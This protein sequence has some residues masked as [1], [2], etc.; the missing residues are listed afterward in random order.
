MT[1]DSAAEVVVGQGLGGGGRDVT[2]VDGEGSGMVIEGED[3]VGL[4]VGIGGVIGGRAGA[5][6]VRALA[7]LGGCQG[8]AV[9][10]STRPPNHRLRSV[11]APVHPQHARLRHPRLD[12]RPPRRLHMHLL[13]PL[14]SRYPLV[15]N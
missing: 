15:I 8:P 10:A 5:A 3:F 1:D 4:V 2:E 13:R 6:A 9:R 7:R 12:L 11:A 14:V